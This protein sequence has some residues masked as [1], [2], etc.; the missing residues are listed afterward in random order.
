MTIASTEAT[1]WGK[2]NDKTDGNNWANSTQCTTA[3]WTALAAKGCVFLPAVGSRSGTTV[4][5]PGD[6]GFYWSS[7]TVNAANAQHLAFNEGLLATQDNADRD[8]GFSIRL[9]YDVKYNLGHR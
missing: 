4:S 3:E 2:I 8:L 7:V 6:R 9:V 1:S 5:F